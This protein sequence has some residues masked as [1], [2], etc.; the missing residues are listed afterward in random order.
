[1]LGYPRPRLYDASWAEYGNADGV[2][3][4]R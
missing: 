1:L 3:V 4:E 2:V